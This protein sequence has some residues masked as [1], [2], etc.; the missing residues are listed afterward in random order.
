MLH[1]DTSDQLIMFLNS[2]HTISSEKFNSQGVLLQFAVF[3]L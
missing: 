2:H 1:I 3:P